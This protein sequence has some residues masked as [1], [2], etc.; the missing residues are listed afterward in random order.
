V[1]DVLPA[2]GRG[3][4]FHTFRRFVD[5]MVVRLPQINEIAIAEWVEVVLSLRPAFDLKNL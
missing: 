5:N 4:N 3:L 1:E 2:A